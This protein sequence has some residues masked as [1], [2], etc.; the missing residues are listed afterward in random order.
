VSR[1]R[2]D[3]RA[4]WFGLLLSL[5]TLLLGFGLGIVFGAAERPLRAS[6]T[7]LAE[8]SIATT[9]PPDGPST[10]VE[11][12][13]EKAWTFLRRSHLHA[14]AMATTSIALISLAPLLGGHVRVRRMIS[15]LL[16]LGS[17]G[18]SVFLIAAALRTP[19]MGDPLAAKE[20][21]RWLAMPSAG[22]YVIAVLVFTLLATRWV[23]QGAGRQN[24]ERPK[25]VVTARGVPIGRPMEAAASNGR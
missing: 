25:V 12:R 8:E 3:L 14:G 10:S 22:V 11:A 16:G 17:L 2:E 6:L 13:V 7:Q 5:G 23:F 20:S 9:P 21:L 19:V 18:Y 1:Y 4:L 24:A 15:S